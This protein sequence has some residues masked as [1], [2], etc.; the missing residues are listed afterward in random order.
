MKVQACK[1]R[2][3]RGT[4]ILKKDVKWEDGIAFVSE[5]FSGGSVD[6]IVDANGRKLASVYDWR[7]MAGPMC[8][9]DTEY[10]P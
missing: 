7:L 5:G 6:F 8:Y 1:F 4:A 10:C 3:E 9:L 2:R